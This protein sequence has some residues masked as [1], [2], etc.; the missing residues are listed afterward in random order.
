M[1]FA[2][3]WLNAVTGTGNTI[4]NLAIEFIAIAL[5]SIYA[6][7]VLEKLQMAITWGWAAE[8]IYWSTMFLLSYLYIKS[9][10]WKKKII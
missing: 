1:S 9:G 8:W 10:R 6:Y 3:V 2:T 7:V 4:I 5:Y